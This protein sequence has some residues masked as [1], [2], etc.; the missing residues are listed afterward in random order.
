MVVRSGR[1]VAGRRCY[2][3]QGERVREPDRERLRPKSNRASALSE[4]APGALHRFHRSMPAFPH[5]PQLWFSIGCAR[6][7]GDGD[8][9]MSV[10]AR[11]D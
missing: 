5:T 11:R 10:P 8:E 3:A 7:D 4:A 6:G 1:W 2:D 9:E